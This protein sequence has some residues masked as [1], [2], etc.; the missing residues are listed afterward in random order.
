M[1]LTAP[2]VSTPADYPRGRISGLVFADLFYNVDGDPK[3]V[4]S[5]SGADQ[6]FSQIDGI[7]PIT[8][9]L[10]GINLRRVYLQLDNDLTV[11][12]A[13]RFRFEVDSKSLT[14]DGK[15]AAFVKN[16]YFLAKSVIPRGDFYFGMLNTPA[17]E[18]A[19]TFWKYR[20]LEKTIADF[21][22][23]ASASD[24]GLS[25]KGFADPAHHFGYW[26]MIGNGTGQ[27]PETDKFKRCYLSLPI[28][29]GDLRVEPYA[30]Y[31]PVR[32]NLLPKVPSHTDSLAVNQD[33]A[34]Y[35]IFAGYDLRRFAVG[36]E[37]VDRLSHRDGISNVEQRGF[38][39]WAR[40]Q[41]RGK[42]DFVARFDN[43]NSDLNTPNR[44]DTQLW[45]FGVDWMPAPD[46]HIEPNVEMETYQKV[47]KPAAVPQNNDIQ[48]RITFYYNFSRPQS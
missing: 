33:Q 11:K 23:L 27:K 16:A 18:N 39:A 31:Q 44:V 12:Y 26:A 10:N 8:K 2:P 25:L 9:D 43:W 42:L 6:G 13:T 48:A 41:M 46:V 3:H 40:T 47:G 32:V 4:Y 7:H 22:G 45:I 37:A 34:M 5:A 21:R 17:F 20:S 19:E 24:L 36:F 30:D 35:K 38:S 28:Q 1:G 14:A 15:I 29:F